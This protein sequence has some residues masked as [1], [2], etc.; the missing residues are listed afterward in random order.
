MPAK[1]TNEEKRAYRESKGL[2]KKKSKTKSKAKHTQPDAS[3]YNTLLQKLNKLSHEVA[4]HAGKKHTPGETA[5]L[6]KQHQ[7]ADTKA[8]AKAKRAKAKAKAKKR[9]DEWALLTPQEKQE[10]KEAS[11]TA[12]RA[13]HIDWTQGQWKHRQEKHDKWQAQE[14]RKYQERQ[15]KRDRQKYKDDIAQAE[16]EN[17]EYEESNAIAETELAEHENA[18][19]DKEEYARQAD[20]RNAQHKWYNNSDEWGKP[21]DRKAV[22]EEYARQAEPGE[23]PKKDYLGGGKAA[24]MRNKSVTPPEDD[25]LFEPENFPTLAQNKI[26]GV[27]SEYAIA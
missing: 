14:T 5:V 11:E 21:E 22:Y 8:K 16:D 15:A 4:K 9:R 24:Q 7:E 6:H 20:Y 2:P 12:F 26:Y 3:Y 27:P 19:Y 1:F 13:K 25:G 23:Y 10:K 18:Q 17:Q